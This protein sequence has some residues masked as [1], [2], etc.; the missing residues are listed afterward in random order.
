[1]GD[2]PPFYVP[3]FVLAPA[4]VSRVAFPSRAFRAN[5]SG[6]A[7]F[8]EPC[9]RSALYHLRQTSVFLVASPSDRNTSMF[10]AE[11]SPEAIFLIK[12]RFSDEGAREGAAIYLRSASPPSFFRN[13]SGG[14]K[15][16]IITDP[17]KM[18]CR[19]RNN[20]IPCF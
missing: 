8:N 9:G 4:S 3:A 18:D 20:P 12:N 7:Y 5:V 10:K 13:Y 16:G 1:M 2:L 17:A 14:T 11:K 15:F 6:L 19:L